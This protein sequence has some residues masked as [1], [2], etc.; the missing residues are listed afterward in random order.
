M[1]LVVSEL[2]LFFQFLARHEQNN[3]ICLFLRMCS[4]GFQTRL[5][6]KD[7]TRTT[8]FLFVFT[9]QPKEFSST[10]TT[11]ARKPWPASLLFNPRILNFMMP[12]RVIFHPD[13]SPWHQSDGTV[14]LEMQHA[15]A[16]QDMAR[17]LCDELTWL[18]F[19]CDRDSADAVNIICYIGRI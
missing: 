13:I 15:E 6:K 14:A 7:Y 4:L 3:F 17:L 18:L 12:L 8:S 10:N 11:Q 1:S 16:E 2:P 5:N 19:C 9:L